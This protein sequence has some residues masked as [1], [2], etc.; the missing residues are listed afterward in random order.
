[1]QNFRVLLFGASGLLGSNVIKFLEINS[2]TYFSTYSR[3]RSRSKDVLFD[4]FELQKLDELVL[5]PIL[6]CIISD[7]G[8]S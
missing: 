6:P 8:S 1:M 4:A 5:M 7:K 3:V 2:I